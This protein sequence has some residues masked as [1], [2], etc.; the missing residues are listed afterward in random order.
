MA[1]IFS[2]IIPVYNDA[3]DLKLVLD[4]IEEQDFPAEN[5]EIFVVDNGSSDNSVEVAKSYSFVAV[6]LEHKNLNS[7]YSCR[8]RGIERAQGDI[9]VLLDASCKPVKN[10]LHFAQ[11]CF[12]DNYVDIL[13]GDVRFDFKEN[14]TSA[15][16]YDSLTNIR[17]QYSIEEKNV[18]KTA[19]L[20]IKK[21]VFD[22]I[23]VFPEGLRSG[24]DVRWTSKA[25]RKG[26]KL[27][28]CKDAVVYK[29]ARSFFELVKKQWRVGVHQPLIYAEQGRDINYLKIIL[30]I[31]YPVKYTYI[32][33]LLSKSNFFNKELNLLSIWCVAQIVRI[34]MCFAN[35]YGGIVH[36]K[37]IIKLTK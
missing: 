2:I 5:F 24:G 3:E 6:L 11:Q 15:K 30:I 35:I 10:W 37:E 29:T 31:F 34:T 22:K 25:K 13:G 16:I 17:M 19:N 7:P 32:K 1:K 23:G 36:R 4:A 33:R 27:E 20:F 28:F 26:Y 9:I 12:E 21:D 18:A 8:N 14:V